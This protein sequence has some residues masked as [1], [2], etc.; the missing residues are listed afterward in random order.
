VFASDHG[1]HFNFLRASSIRGNFFPKQ[2]FVSKFSSKIAQAD[3]VL[4]D[5]PRNTTHG[6]TPWR[7]G[8]GL[9]KIRTSIKPGNPTVWQAVTEHVPD[10]LG[11]L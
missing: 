2:S 3:L 6:V 1:H 5:I 11:H 4:D 9:I 8:A 7:L 10:L